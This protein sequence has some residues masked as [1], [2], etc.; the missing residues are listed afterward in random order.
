MQTLGQM[1]DLVIGHS[2][3]AAITL[4]MCLD[5]LITPKAVLGLN[6]ALLPP[7]GYGR[8]VFLSRGQTH[9]GSAVC[10][11]AVCLARVRPLGA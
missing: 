4:R 11:Q 9:G 2:A 8:P 7:G 1:P 10:A 3:G 5:G 6:G